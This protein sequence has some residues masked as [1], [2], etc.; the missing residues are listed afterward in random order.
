MGW[1]PW[2]LMDDEAVCQF[3]L[4]MFSLF[5]PMNCWTPTA[6]SFVEDNSCPAILSTRFNTLAFQEFLQMCWHRG[7]AVHPLFETIIKDV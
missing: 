7:P 5:I 6:S 4:S 3:L 2:P 1:M